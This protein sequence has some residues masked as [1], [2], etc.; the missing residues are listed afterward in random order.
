MEPGG[1]KN[2]VRAA[3]SNPG[4]SLC[5]AMQVLTAHV[6]TAPQTAEQVRDGTRAKSGVSLTPESAFQA[7]TLY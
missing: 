6:K 5:P 4:S 3:I 1:D 7:L 2:T